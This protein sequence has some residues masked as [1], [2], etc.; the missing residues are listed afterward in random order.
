MWGDM[1]NKFELEHSEH[2]VV[3][4]K[5]VTISEYNGKSLNSNESSTIAI[6]PQHKRT[7]QL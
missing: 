4:I 5:R 3:A 6:N 2:P 7:K 1:A